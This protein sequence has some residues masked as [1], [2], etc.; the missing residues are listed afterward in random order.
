MYIT[1]ILYTH[2]IPDMSPMKSWVIDFRACTGKGDLL[3]PWRIAKWLEL[4]P[5]L[6]CPLQGPMQGDRIQPET[7]CARKGNGSSDQLTSRDC[8]ELCGTREKGRSAMWRSYAPFSYNKTKACADLVLLR[9]KMQAFWMRGAEQNSFRYSAYLS[10]LHFTTCISSIC[11]HLQLH[12]CSVLYLG[13]CRQ[14]YIK[15]C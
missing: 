6:H 7:H 4:P 14:V 15:T 3:A 9:S 2:C 5:T 8:F 12:S 1:Y 11:I 10:S 13:A